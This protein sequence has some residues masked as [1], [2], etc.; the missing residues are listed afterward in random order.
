MTSRAPRACARSSARRTRVD[1]GASTG[2][3]PGISTVS[4]E[5]RADSPRDTDSAYPDVVGTGPGVSVHTSN[6]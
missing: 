3:Q 6:S 1:S 5:A 4:A 2:A